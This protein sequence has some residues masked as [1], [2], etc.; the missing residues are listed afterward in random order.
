MQNNLSSQLPS[1]N[2]VRPDLLAQS[3]KSTTTSYKFL[4]LS[5]LVRG[6]E[7]GKLS[8]DLPDLALEM[9][10]QAWWPVL[11]YRLT[12]GAADQVEVVL[13]EWAQEEPSLRRT[14]TEE[15]RRFLRRKGHVR[16]LD[17]LVRYVP[18]R[19]IRPWFREEVKGLPDHKVDA[20]IA[21]LSCD[22]FDRTIPL[23]R[24]LGRQLELHPEWAAYIRENIAIVKGWLE[25]RWIEFLER[26]NP[27][28]PGL[29]QKLTAPSQRRSLNNQRKI[30]SHV[31]TKVDLRCIYSDRALSPHS[32]ALDHFVPRSFVGHDRFWNLT[33]TYTEINSA[34]SDQ[35]PPVSSIEPLFDQHRRVLEVMCEHHG[36]LKSVWRKIGEEYQIDLRLSEAVKAGNGE[37]EDAFKTTHGALLGIA[38]RMWYPVMREI[39]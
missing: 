16:Q 10:V 33:P 22:Q 14:S 18:Q 11:H 2:A 36:A 12:F 39:E 8:H 5:A 37:V 13:L 26:R 7:D 6:V 24:V 20:T 4:L 35:L 3:F 19:L 23:Y 27:N 38:G 1:S 25:F 29:A 9:L 17:S 30:W 32:F 21:V 15:V 28:V 34:K 31:L